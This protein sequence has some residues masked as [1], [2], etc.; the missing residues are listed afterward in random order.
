MLLL[1]KR[2]LKR[3]E[4]H[5]IQG[6]S[7]PL[8]A[9]T[10]L[11]LRGKPEISALGYV[12]ATLIGHGLLFS[13]VPSCNS[14]G[15]IVSPSCEV[16]SGDVHSFLCVLMSPYGL[17]SKNWKC[18]RTAIGMLMALLHKLYPSV[19]EPILPNLSISELRGPSALDALI[20]SMTGISP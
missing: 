11:S 13:T 3:R 6:V 19:D 1:F 2:M 8:A 4:M 20:F 18:R 5:F 17:D 12:C 15:L 14:D 9:I 7:A 10:L 16:V